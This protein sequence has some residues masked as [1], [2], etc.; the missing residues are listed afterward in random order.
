MEM[1]PASSD[2]ARGLLISS[3][4]SLNPTAG[5]FHSEMASDHLDLSG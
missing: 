1:V 3:V 4:T 2:G 5:P